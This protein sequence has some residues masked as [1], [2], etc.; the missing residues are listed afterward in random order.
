VKRLEDLTQ[1][2]LDGSLTAAEARELEAWL[3]RDAAAARLHRELLAVEVALRDLDET[4]DVSDAVMATIAPIGGSARPAKA[5]SQRPAD[6]WFLRVAVP[7]AAAAGMAL[8]FLLF[9]QFRPA[10][11]TT[12][13]DLAGLGARAHGLRVLRGGVP[14]PPGSAS[15]LR[16]GDRLIAPAD[17]DARLVYADRTLLRLASGTELVFEPSLAAPVPAG[18]RLELVS[19]TVRAE[20]PKQAGG[21]F[22]LRA[23]D[24]WAV[25][26]GTVFHL[27]AEPG[28]A[29]LSVDEGRV[30]LIRVRD[31]AQATVDAGR[32]ALGGADRKPSSRPRRVTEGLEAYYTFEETSGSTVP[33][34]SGAPDAF[35]L[36]P[37]GNRPPPW[38]R[39]S[40]GLSLSSGG[41]LASDGPAHRLREAC[42]YTRALTLEAWVRPADRTQSGPATIL[43]L[44]GPGD[45]VNALL[46]HGPSKDAADAFTVRLRTSRFPDGA[47]LHAP[48]G[49]VTDQ[50]T[51]V[52]F[53]RDRNGSASLY[54]NGKRVAQR[55]IEGDFA[56][57]HDEASLVLGPWNGTYRLAAVYSRALSSREILRNFESGPDQR[58]AVPFPDP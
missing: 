45:R 42:R 1:K 3:E 39:S 57:W 18:K 52:A 8:T 49:S 26:R 56:N 10:P 27:T 15:S 36:S 12:G 7:V 44:A 58:A 11:A 22:V 33:D 14:L 34:R 24:T 48:R 50:A 29:W 5:G 37:A 46:G 35:P 19:G 53:T 16:P 41:A 17:A 55:K 38:K 28:L 25:V 2:Q 43:A 9:H 13:P 54:V 4:F 32:F 47:S 21:A 31:G 40:A 6:W 30:D 23:A 51:H 20:V